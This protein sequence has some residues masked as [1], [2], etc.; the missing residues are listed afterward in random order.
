MEEAVDGV[1]IELRAKE[2]ELGAVP[3]SRLT[4]YLHLEA[5]QPELVSV[6]E[7]EVPLN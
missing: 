5:R 6:V 3:F 7:V 4:S 2:F 1:L